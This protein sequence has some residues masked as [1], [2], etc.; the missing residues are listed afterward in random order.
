MCILASLMTSFTLVVPIVV[1]IVI[2]IV[3]S[4]GALI[5]EF[6]KAKERRRRSCKS[7][8]EQGIGNSMLEWEDIDTLAQRWKQSRTDIYWILSDLLR[9]SLTAKDG[10]GKDLYQKIKELMKKQQ[11]T[12]PFSELP[13]SIRMHIETVSSRF[14][15]KGD[16]V[17][18]P[19]VSS[20]CDTIVE[21]D[22]KAEAQRSFTKYSFFVGI[23]S[24][25]I[26]I[27]SLTFAIT[28]IR[29]DI[30]E[31]IPRNTK[32]V[33]TSPESGEM[34]IQHPTRNNQ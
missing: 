6:F 4:L 32:T 20:I 9:E 25:L 10:K 17:L 29:S 23:I 11:D 15:A 28:Q 5:P 3:L 22:R 26:G 12:E 7:D 16:E 8:I 14:T 30:N 2:A 24:L 1:A 34:N 33:T 18:R 27:A 31:R 13:E 21:A 19:L